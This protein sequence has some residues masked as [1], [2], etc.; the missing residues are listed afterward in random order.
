MT[1]YIEREAALD[2][3]ACDLGK[4]DYSVSYQGFMTESAFRINAIP[5]ADVAPVRHGR[6]VLNPNLGCVGGDFGHWICSE[7]AHEAVFG[8]KRFDL[9][10]FN[11]CP[12]CG[13]LMDKEGD[14][15]D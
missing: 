2:C 7:C 14:G 10:R 15:D 13:A 1:D 9:K 5:A 4:K 11:Y 12:N 3:F 8:D 6:W